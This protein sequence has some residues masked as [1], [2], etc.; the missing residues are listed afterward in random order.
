MA[1]EQNPPAAPPPSGPARTWPPVADR[2]LLGKPIRRIDGPDK[3]QGK[4]KYTYDIVRPGMLYGRLLSSPHPYAVVKSIDVTPAL[5]VPGVKAAI[6][7]KD[8]AGPTAKIWYQGEEVAAV[9]ATTEEAAEDAV[10]AIK[11][12]YEILPALATVEQSMSANAPVNFPK[13]NVSAERLTLRPDKADV[14]AALKASAHIVEGTYSTQVQTH[15]SLETHGGICEW[16]G[17]KLTA[18]VSTQAV[19]ATRD[20]LS[21]ALQ[22]QQSDVHVITDYMGGGFG[23]KLG[24]DVQVV[25]AAKLAKEAGA[26]VKL[27]LTRKEE[28]LITGNRPSAYAKVKAGVDAQGKLTAF[29]AETWGTGG[30]GQ[31]A[32]FNIPYPVYAFGVLRQRHKDVFINAGPQ[33]AMRAPGHPQ[34]CFITEVVVDELA[35]R[36]RMDPLELRMRNL[37][38]AGPDGQD[39]PTQQ[40]RKYFPMAAD[41]IGWSRRHAT[42]DTGSGP[43][44]RGMGCAA[45]RWAGGGSNR[46]RAACEI[47][48]D[49]GVVMRIGTQDIGTGT[50]TLVAMITA[51]TMGLPLT[52]VKAAIGDSE[53]PWAPGSGGSTTVG[54]ISPTVRIAAENARDALFAKVA[55]SLR[56]EPAA[57]VAKDGRVQVKDNPAKGMTWKEAC[58]LLGVQPISADGAWQQGLSSSGTSGVQFADVEVDIE[59]GITRVKRVVCVQ[60]CGMIVDR[61]TAESQVYGGIIMGIGFALFEHR[62]LDRNTAK[63]VNPNMEFYLLPGMSDIPEIDITLIDQPERGPVGLGEPPTISTAAAIANAIANATGARVRSLPLTPAAVLAALHEE[64]SGG[65]R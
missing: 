5:K 17:E 48:P 24:P 19:H 62:I 6:A 3:S 61:I 22:M 50:R 27:M 11:V 63:M 2:A 29:D 56:V 35:D 40:W 37:P 55:P 28:H 20:G 36:L 38:P 1:D 9:A 14:E 57:L 58:R 8:P 23:S 25:I 21:R 12:E 31:G 16:N 64:R 32:G 59:T 44:K 43:I 60:D 4:A 34:A 42:A 13:G 7:L 30:A 53:Y 52:A 26:P 33:R 49:G 41:K 15:T 39:L 54:S 65:T 51:E 18:W 10:R 45:N 47:L 46:T